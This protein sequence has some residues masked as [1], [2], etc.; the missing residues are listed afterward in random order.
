MSIHDRIG[1]QID[2]AKAYAEDGAFR[3]AAR[4]FRN[5]AEELDAHSKHCDGLLT[6]L[7]KPQG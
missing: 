7:K 5:L 3:T 4:I 6:E 1:E 2:L